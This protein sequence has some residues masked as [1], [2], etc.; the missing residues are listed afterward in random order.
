MRYLIVAIDFI[1]GLKIV[2]NF[3]FVLSNGDCE[4]LK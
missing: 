1:F 4:E 2:A 3:V